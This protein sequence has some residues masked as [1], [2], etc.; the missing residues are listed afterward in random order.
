MNGSSVPC[1]ERLGCPPKEGHSGGG[2]GVQGMGCCCWCCCCSI[3][4]ASFS[5]CFGSALFYGAFFIFIAA[6]AAAASLQACMCV[7]RRLGQGHL[8]HHALVAGPV[9][10]NTPQ[11]NKQAMK[12]IICTGQTCKSSRRTDMHETHSIS[13]TYRAASS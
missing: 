6:Q 3:L 1:S 12:Q 4:K 8:Q 13:S 5:S 9:R 10:A 2:W 11:Q 7:G